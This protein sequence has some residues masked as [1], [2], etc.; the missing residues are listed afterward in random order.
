MINM[1]KAINILEAREQRSQ[2]IKKLTNQTNYTIVS[3]QVNYPGINKLNDTTKNI[4]LLFHD[5]IINMICPVIYD[6]EESFDGPNRIY[7]VDDDREEVKRSC[8]HLEETHPL[9]RFIDIDVYKIN[10]IPLS[11]TELGIKSRKC[12]ICNDD[13]KICRRLNKHTVDE[14]ITHIENLLYNFMSSN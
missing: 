9:G 11:R 8:V 12:F 14:L 5:E 4:S 13:S 3:M 7:L 10:G 1:L 2:Y 6:Y